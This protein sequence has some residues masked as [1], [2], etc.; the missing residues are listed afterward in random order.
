MPIEVGDDPVIRPVTATRV[1]ESGA[2]VVT[3]YPPSGSEGSY[4]GDVGTDP[5]L[6]TGVGVGGDQSEGV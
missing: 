6:G 1:D 2:T 3:G 4:N 5:N